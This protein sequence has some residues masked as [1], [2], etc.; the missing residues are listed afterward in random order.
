MYNI[1]DI[2]ALKSN[3]A[4]KMTVSELD[5][6]DETIGCTFVNKNQKIEEI[7][8]NPQ[9]LTSISE[10]IKELELNEIPLIYSKGKDCYSFYKYKSIIASNMHGENSDNTATAGTRLV[11]NF[12]K[13]YP[14]NKQDFY[15]LVTIAKHYLKCEQIVCVPGHTLELNSLQKTF[16]VTIE[17]IKNSEPRKYNHKKSLP[18]DYSDTYSIDFTKLQQNILLLDDVL[19]SGA[20][21]NHF[22]NELQN[23]GFTVKCLALGIDHKIQTEMINTFW[24]FK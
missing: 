2:V 5:T 6:I 19:T 1:G 9:I 24:L 4:F 21:M 3:L 12:K 11:F 20:T 13:Y 18:K 15:N 7:F 8:L 22:R 17:R 10:S 14:S 23:K 16:G